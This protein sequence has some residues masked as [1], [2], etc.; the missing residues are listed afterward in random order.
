[1][2]AAKSN[3]GAADL[4]V[5]EFMIASADPGIRLYVRNKHPADQ[6]GFASERTLLFVHG[7]SQPAEATFEF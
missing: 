1:M 6:Q 3:A 4:V 5:E 7:A 2:P